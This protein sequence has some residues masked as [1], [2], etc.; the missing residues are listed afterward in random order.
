LLKAAFH[1][2][3]NTEAASMPTVQQF[4]LEAEAQK[5]VV[6]PSMV[7]LK[8]E[9]SPKVEERPPMIVPILEKHIVVGRQLDEEEEERAG[10]EASRMDR[11]AEDQ[12]LME[13]VPP[14]E[15]EKVI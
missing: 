6:I 1:P 7:P 15:L 3:P 13:I 11:N 4:S 2:Q 12:K 5:L 9:E 14:M 10:N 8:V